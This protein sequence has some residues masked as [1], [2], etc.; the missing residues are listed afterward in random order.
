M[1]YSHILFC[2]ENSKLVIVFLPT[3]ITHAH[4][5]PCTIPSTEL[6]WILDFKQI[7]LLL[8]LFSTFIPLPLSPC[9]SVCGVLIIIG[10]ARFVDRINS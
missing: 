4:S 6:V 9:S 2:N 8:L 5:Q 1:F 10:A 7:L 3:T